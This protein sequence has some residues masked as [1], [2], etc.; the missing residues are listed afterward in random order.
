MQVLISSDRPSAAF[1][2]QNGSAKKGLYSNHKY[3]YPF[4]R[5]WRG[6]SKY[7][8]LEPQATSDT[9]QV[10]DRKTMHYLCRIRR[11]MITNILTI[12]WQCGMEYP[13]NM[14]TNV[15][16]HARFAACWCYRFDTPCHRDDVGVSFG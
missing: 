14:I 9:I 3:H 11:E 10:C 5:G 12:I 1:L 15:R 2:T 16:T 13:W 7:I 8:V 4:D 6:I